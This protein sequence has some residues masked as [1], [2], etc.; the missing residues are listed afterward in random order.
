MLEVPRQDPSGSPRASS[1]P[2][3]NVS[4]EHAPLTEGYTEAQAVSRRGDS[5]PSILP[6]SGEPSQHSAEGAV[7]TGASARPAVLAA[8]AKATIYK[9]VSSA[10]HAGSQ[11]SA[12]AG[13]EPG[14]RESAPGR[15]GRLDPA[16]PRWEAR[17]R[18][19]SP[20]LHAQVAVPAL[21]TALYSLRR[22]FHS[23]NTSNCAHITP[24][25]QDQASRMTGGETEAQRGEVLCTKSHSK[26][27]GREPPEPGREGTEAR[28]PGA[29][30]APPFSQPLL[31][32]CP[33]APGPRPTWNSF[34]PVGRG[35]E[36]FSGTETPQD[37]KDH[38]PHT[39]L[40]AG[41]CVE[42]YKNPAL[43]CGAARQLPMKG[44]R[45]RGTFRMLWVPR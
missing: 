28:I 13:R 16:E 3:Q 5:V 14:G 26:F 19:A 21:P 2:S 23:C 1:S 34:S 40:P 6:R 10:R 30:L 27:G 31:R 8:V 45:E 17:A 38:P 36:D 37:P 29:L 20:T 39:H 24:G 33:E 35:P 25:E 4:Q 44:V 22:V 43:P 15:E 18:L 11:R 41:G 42:G 32:S 9:A 12:L 7:G